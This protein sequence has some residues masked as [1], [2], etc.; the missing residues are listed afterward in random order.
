LVG[1]VARIRPVRSADA[2]AIWRIFQQVAAAG[3]SY[4]FAADTT[5]ADAD[6]YFLTPGIT[7]FVAEVDGRVAGFYKLIPNRRDRGA[8]VANASFMVDPAAAGRGIGRALGEHC[9]REARRRGYEAMQFNFVVSTNERAVALWQSLGFAIVA[10]LPRVFRHATL[11][12]VDAFVMF[13]S[14]DDLPA[15]EMPTF[16]ERVA[17]Y[18]LRPRPSAYTLVQ[19]DSQSVAVVTTPEG[20]FLPGGGIDAGEWAELAAVRETREECAIDVRT[21]WLIGRATD[22]VFSKKENAC[23]EKTSTFVAADLIGPVAQTPE[24]DVRWLP[25]DEAAR[26]VTRNGHAWA[27]R[28]WSERRQQIED[29]L[30]A[31]SR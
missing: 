11:G 26:T 19:S 31:D 22:I 8:H 17:G 18:E 2:D 25:L 3:D 10:T 24:H 13:R 7:T 20:V 30:T 9:L 14:L 1:P 4:V 29:A 21:T 16:G 23:F 5:R 6:A 15:D 27:I 28:Q 12:D